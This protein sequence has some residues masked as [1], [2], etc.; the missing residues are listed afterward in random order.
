MQL[1]CQ[2]EAVSWDH[3]SMP[4]AILGSIPDSHVLITLKCRHQGPIL[5]NNGV[6]SDPE[7]QSVHRRP[8]RQ[9]PAA[10]SSSG[11]RRVENW[12]YWDVTPCTQAEIYRRF[13]GMFCQSKKSSTCLP[14]LLLYP[15]DGGSTFLETSA[16]VFLYTRHNSLEHRIFRI[17]V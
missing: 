17:F 7:V 8:L 14:Y 9:Q 12:R 15:D 5:R 6:S 16:N 4:F 13:G 2:F 11:P 3:Y 1:G 10:R